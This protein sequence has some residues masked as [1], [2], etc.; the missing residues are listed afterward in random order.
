VLD[1][2]V[3]LLEGALVEQGQ[4]ALARGQ[5]ALGVLPLAALGPAARL[6]ARDLVAQH[7]ERRGFLAGHQWQPQPP[8]PQQPPPPPLAHAHRAPPP[9]VPAMAKVE[10]CFSTVADA[11]AGQ[12]TASF[13]VRT[14]FSK[15]RP[16]SVQRYS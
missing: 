2:L 4:H 5:L 12:S 6:G 11:Q 3:E 1:Q 9:S 10:T 15:S 7:R 8:R 16:Q 13:Q 14:S